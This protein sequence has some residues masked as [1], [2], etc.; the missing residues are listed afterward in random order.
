MLPAYVD[1]TSDSSCLRGYN[2]R[3][4]LATWMKEKSASFSVCGRDRY[5][6]LLA[7]ADR[8]EMNQLYFLA[9]IKQ[10]TVS[11]SLRE[12]GH[13]PTHPP[14]RGKTN[15]KLAFKRKKFGLQFSTRR[16]AKDVSALVFSAQL[17]SLAGPFFFSLFVRWKLQSAR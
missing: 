8:T 17:R 15:F 10:E 1:T 9:R 4:F 13:S 16:S 14:S 12:K 7:S 6:P 2:I 3:L 5:Q 11:S